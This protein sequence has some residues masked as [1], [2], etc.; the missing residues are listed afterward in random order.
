MTKK[1]DKPITLKK[2]REY[3]MRMIP[4]DSPLGRPIEWTDD[5]I[6][7]EAIAL[8]AWMKDENNYYFVDF[9]LER[10]Y[11]SNTLHEL[12]QK[13][14]SFSKT[15]L[16]AREAQERKIVKESLERR[17]DGNF[18]KFVLANKHGYKEKTEISGDA[19]NPLSFILG[20]IDGKTKDII[21]VT[22]EAAS[23]GE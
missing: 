23:N 4:K 14:A 3:K 19:A 7:Q 15:F 2:K 13:S 10:G 22:P 8:D 17:Y 5:R 18:A 1:E 11:T 16:R 21:D 20:N 12:A 6:A 9:A